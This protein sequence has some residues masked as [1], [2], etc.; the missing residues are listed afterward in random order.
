LEVLEHRRV[1]A[2]ILV[3][4]ITGLS[5]LVT[6]SNITP[7]DSMM[8]VGPSSVINAV[9][10]AL[11]IQ[12]KAGATIAPATE[13]STFFAPVITPGDDFTDPQVMYDDLAGR[14]YVC[15]LEMSAAGNADLDFAVSKTSSPTDFS[16]A[17]WTEFTRIRAV[18]EGGTAFADYP[19]MG[20]NTDA[21]FVSLNQFPSA[22][23][24]VHD[25]MQPRSQV[26]DPRQSPV[27][28]LIV[29]ISKAAIL[30]GTPLAQNTNY[31]LTDVTTDL[32]QGDGDHRILIP[33]RMHGAQPG[34]LEYFVQRDQDLTSESRSSVNVVT[35]QGYLGGSAGFVTHTFD[36]NAYD[37]SPGTYSTSLIDDRVL[38]AD[39]IN[40]TLV[41][42]QNVGMVGSMLSL[43]RWYEFNTAGSITLAQQGDVSLGSGIDT[44]FPSIAIA[45]G[46]NIGMTFIASN[47]DG[48]LAP[49]VYV[50]GRRATDA[51]GTMEAPVLVQAGVP[52]PSQGTRSGDYSAA[53]YDPVD[54]SFWAVNEYNVDAGSTD[55]WGTAIA[56]FQLGGVFNVNTTADPSI[57]GGVD[58]ATGQIIGQGNTVSL[59]SA[60]QAANSLPG[61]NTINLIAQGLY[62][63]ELAGAAGETD[64]QAGEFAIVPN[65]APLTIQNA[66]GGSVVVEGNNLARVFDIDPAAT[67]ASGFSVLFE[68]FTIQGGSASGSQAGGD[69]GGIR[70][71]GNASLT[72]TNMILSNNAAAANG[73]GIAMESAPGSSWTLTLANTSLTSN[74][75]GAA[76]GGLETAGPGTIAIR[77]G[78]A[79]SGN[80][81][82]SGGGGIWLNAIAAGSLLQ[83]ATLTMAGTV[84]SGNATTGPGSVGG[85]IGTS[86]DGAVTLADSTIE[87]DQSK[88]AGGGFGEWNDLG[89]LVVDTSLFLSCSAGGDGGA[90]QEGGPATTITESELKGNSSGGSGG[91][92]F[93]SGT[94]LS[95][96]R[97]TFTNNTAAGGGGID[98]DTSGAG[99][100]GSQIVNS[101]FVANTATNS[102][103]AIDA[104]ASFNGSLVLVN[105]TINANGAASGG[106]VFWAGASHSTL[107]VQNTIIAQ[108]T[109]GTGS[110]ASN[111]AGTFTDQGGNL[112][113]ISGAGSGNT[114]FTAPSTQ[115][116]STAHPLDPGLG[117]LQNNGA[118]TATLVLETEALQAGSPALNAG[119]AGTAAVDEPGFARDNPPDTGAFEALTPAWSYVSVAYGLLLNR[120]T[121]PAAQGWVN[122]LNTGV[123]PANVV[124]GIESST[125]Y[126]TD[127]VAGLY[128]RYLYRAPDPAG[129]QWWLSMLGGGAT[130]EQVA[131]SI[132]GSPEYLALHGGSDASFVA[133]LYQD[134][135][136]RTADSGGEAYWVSA[137]NSGASRAAVALGFLT[138]TEYRD[139]LV[140]AD[141]M[142][143]LGRPADSAGLSYWAAALAS[144]LTDQA[145]LAG[146]FGSPEGFN[147]WS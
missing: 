73:G 67:A 41:A 98:V 92:I 131:A 105:D 71:Q 1:P 55:D 3:Q 6:S 144:G 66:T 87:Q 31:F 118:A 94:T 48:S 143:F 132:V 135:L 75:A 40:N 102:G 127:V 27:H 76:G 22:G 125:E 2:V 78:T 141:Y 12:S 20:W 5:Y 128:Q 59:R 36:V 77:A 139:N 107:G 136:G 18:E 4:G 84:V 58:P 93:D 13:F 64:N 44:S 119:L 145:L 54:G 57:A 49:S 134:V 82:V 114:G 37:D 53:E 11:R 137:L 26:T 124:G 95:V 72:L 86:G 69:G 65:T 101:T 123:S 8:A 60:I 10:T 14:F 91:S 28:D 110:D 83:S 63:I 70:V 9:N 88:G 104:P 96:M 133:A 81:S 117:P 112:I 38:S 35:M 100:A 142:Q 62:Q 29:S 19:Q 80:K 52:N 7:P 89:T 79:I 109:A 74:Q 111:A 121:D 68:G 43:S 21:V 33:A 45:P 47:Q 39:W 115:S 129:S 126:L 138:S 51:A 106:G 25:T 42:T 61:P 17:S 108:N 85:G 56:H 103:G 147:K 34:N 116:G 120:S 113:G 99:G 24:P 15:T 23:G 130:I 50:T 16:S 97:S 146:I 140:N 32:G 122:R 46:G 30:A 90:I